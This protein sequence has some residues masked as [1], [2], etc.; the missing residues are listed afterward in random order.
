MKKSVIKRRKRVVP[1]T[2]GHPEFSTEAAVSPESD[3]SHHAPDDESA[4]RGALNPD[5]S[6]SLGFR[7]RAEPSRNLPELPGA[8]RNGHQA[9]MAGAANDLGSYATHAH[10]QGHHQSSLNSQNRLPPMT[11]YPS[12]GQ[13]PSSLSPGVLLSPNRKRSFSTLDEEQQQ[14]QQQQQQTQGGERDSMRLSSIKSILNPSQQGTVEEKLDP[15]LRNQ[16]QRGEGQGYANA[17]VAQMGGEERDRERERERERENERARMERREMLRREAE[18]MRE[19]LR[20][21]ERELEELNR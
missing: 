3:E 14:Q 15:S 12:P 5:G 4:P 20:E 17:S 9:Q 7:R 10:A 1:A 2:A 8:L 13:R 16:S 6:I 21:K 19:E 11:A 18:R